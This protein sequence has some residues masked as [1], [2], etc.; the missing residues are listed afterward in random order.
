MSGLAGMTA[1][2]DEAGTSLAH[3]VIATDGFPSRDERC[4]A[5]SHFLW[6]HR[7]FLLKTRR[8]IPV[9]GARCSVLCSTLPPPSRTHWPSNTVAGGGVSAG[10]KRKSFLTSGCV[11]A[12]V[13]SHRQ[14]CLSQP[15]DS[16]SLLTAWVAVLR[17]AQAPLF[18]ELGI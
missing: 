11:V 8:R 7:Y 12:V 1:T 5:R 15:D 9:L 4:A 6:R 14:R 3:D 18:I 10:A 2:D 16:L 13:V 17:L